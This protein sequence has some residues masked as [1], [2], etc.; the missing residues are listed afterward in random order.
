M[1]SNF[2]SNQLLLYSQERDPLEGPVP[3]LEAH[4][5]IFLSIV[6]LPIANVFEVEAKSQSPSFKNLGGN[7][8][9]L[10]VE[11]CSARNLSDSSAY[12]WLGYVSSLMVSS[13]LSLVKKSTWFSVMEGDPLNG[14]LVN[15]FLTTPA[16][17]LAAIEKLYHIAL[18]GLVEEK[19]AT[20]KILCGAS[21]SCGW[22]FQIPFAFLS[23]S[24]VEILQTPFELCTTG[25]AMGSEL[26]LE[27]LLLLRNSHIAS[28]NSTVQDDMDS[29]FEQ[30]EFAS[31]KP[32]Y[33]D[34]F[35]K[36]RGWY[37]QNR[38]CIASMLFGLCS[39]T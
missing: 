33:I 11:A 2:P 17:S 25:G 19:L 13:E 9:H 15:S 28:Q 32:I 10:I 22:N 8:R 5:C 39:G 20:A 12:F 26:T 35:P 38:S 6:P 23:P 24:S 29:N 31:D 14:H 1:G 37:C 30:L 34:Y 4:F 18:N 36:L 27:Y 16:S 3:H 7:M 21:L